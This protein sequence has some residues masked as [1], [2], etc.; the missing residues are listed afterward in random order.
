M[1]IY[2]KITR[3]APRIRYLLALGR[4]TVLVFE[5]LPIVDSSQKNRRMCDMFRR[6][7]QF[8]NHVCGS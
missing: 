6:I 8:S 4:F 3:N 5:R 7:V 1:L 2:V